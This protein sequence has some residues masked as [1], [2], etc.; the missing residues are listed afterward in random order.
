M[1]DTATYTP[2]YYEP[3]AYEREHIRITHTNLPD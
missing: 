3:T 1:S 2:R